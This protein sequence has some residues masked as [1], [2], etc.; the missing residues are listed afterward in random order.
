M[1]VPTFK[2]KLWAFTMGAAVGGLSGA[3]FAT[4]QGFINPES[5]PVLTSILFLAAVVVGG[6]GNL[7]GVIVGPIVVAFL[8]E[9]F[10]GLSEYRF[11]IFGL[12]LM[13]MSIFRPQGLIPSRRRA[14]ELADRQ[15]EVEAGVNA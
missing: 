15:K 12:A 9:R 4:K 8:P 1:G 13:L 3:L 14:V 7:L 11:L 10:R 6:A 5:F 2:F